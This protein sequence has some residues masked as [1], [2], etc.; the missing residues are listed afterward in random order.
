MSRAVRAKRMSRAAVLQPPRC[1]AGGW[2]RPG[3]CAMCWTPPPILAA[4]QP[5]AVLSAACSCMLCNGPPRAAHAHALHFYSSRTPLPSLQHTGLHQPQ[6]RRSCARTCSSRDG[7]AGR[8]HPARAWH[9][10][11]SAAHAARPRACSRAA[12]V[13]LQGTG[14][15]MPEPRLQVHATNEMRLMLQ[16]YPHCRHHI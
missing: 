1:A 10:K 12:W 11:W 3:L 2:H 15:C 8:A 9:M 5:P 6:R 13:V 7:V 16:P 4:R 14:L